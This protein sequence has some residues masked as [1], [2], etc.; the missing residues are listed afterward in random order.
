MGKDA[1]WYKPAETILLT[2]AGFTKNFR[3]YLASEMWAAILSQP[4]ITRDFDLRKEML[5]ELD[6]EKI[7]DRIMKPDGY[8]DEQKS[9][10][11][12]GLSN[13]YQQM[14]EA[15][16]TGD[17]D[18]RHLNSAA[19]A[20]SHLIRRFAGSKDRCTGGFFFTLNQDLFVERF[21]SNSDTTISIDIP[22]LP[23]RSPRWFNGT[24][25]VQLEPDD[26]VKLPDH[27]WLQKYKADFWSKRSYRPLAYIKLHGSYSWQFHDGTPG[28]VIGHAKTDLLK[29]EPLLNWYQSLFEEVLCAGDRKLVVAGYGFND[30]HINAV[31]A[32]GIKSH[33]LKLYAVYPYQPKEFQ[34]EL[35]AYVVSGFDFPKPHCEVIW[36]GLAGYFPIKV[37]EICDQQSSSRAPARGNHLL[38]AVG[39]I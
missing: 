33:G 24:L 19:A 29:K 39:L 5:N 18:P 1:D 38:R 2:G 23:R 20:C 14:H 16:C 8:R 7:Y 30:E 6:Y 27:D 35:G 4:A 21:Y 36:D 3:G 15:I 17:V 32:N 22:G 28:L 11:R 9:S 25:D 34:R 10:F 37:T 13:A 12:T 31:I 26:W